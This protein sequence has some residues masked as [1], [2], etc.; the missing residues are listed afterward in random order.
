MRVT[1]IRHEVDKVRNKVTCA[2]GLQSTS[3]HQQ[4]NKKRPSIGYLG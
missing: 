3:A 2:D 4:K 1:M